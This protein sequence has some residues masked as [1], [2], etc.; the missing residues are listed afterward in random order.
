MKLDYYES[1]L[2]LAC[3]WN[4][5]ILN[6]NWIKKYLVDSINTNGE[7]SNNF[8]VNVEMTPDRP[9][10]NAIVHVSFD[11]VKLIFMSGRIELRLTE[12]SNFALLEKYALRICEYLPNTP[13]VAYGVNFTF[14][15]DKLCKGVLD[16]TKAVRTS[17]F[18][19]PLI[20]EQYTL[21]F[22][23]DNIDINIEIVVNPADKTS[24]FKLNFNF[25]IEYLSEFS[26]RI[27]EN[28]ISA[29]K[30]KAVELLLSSYGLKLVV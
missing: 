6:P 8:T 20:S 17:D 22:N 3:G 1:P 7:N 15:D 28:S 30:E 16:I 2:V 4:P 13:A 26:P 25:P 14:A 24:I 5:N 23:L 21:N 12:G 27:S 29:L 10:R 9:I 18:G 19:A 11:K